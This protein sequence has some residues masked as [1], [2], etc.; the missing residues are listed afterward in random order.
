MTEL[1][2]QKQHLQEN[3]DLLLKEKGANAYTRILQKQIAGFDDPAE[4]QDAYVVS[5]G[6]GEEKHG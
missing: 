2:D 1:F 5:V 3:L 6:S 4:D